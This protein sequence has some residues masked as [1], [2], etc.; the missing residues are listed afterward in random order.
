[1]AVDWSP[2]LRGKLADRVATGVPAAR[3]QALA[4]QINTLP[5]ELKLHSRVAKVYEDRLKMATGELRMDWGFAETMAYATAAGLRCRRVFFHASTAV[6]W[7]R[8]W[9]SSFPH[10]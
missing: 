8:Q 10:E 6:F 7:Q 9:G 2:Y 4:T 3:I 1:M 5:A